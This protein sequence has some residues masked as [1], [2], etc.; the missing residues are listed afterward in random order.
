MQSTHT[1]KVGWLKTRNY[2]HVKVASITS[3]QY[4]RDQLSKNGRKKT[5]ALEDIIRQYENQTQ[6][7]K[8]WTYTKAWH[9]APRDD[10]KAST[11]YNEPEI[12]SN[13]TVNL[14]T[15]NTMQNNIAMANRARPVQTLNHAKM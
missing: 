6:Q 4:L 14:H 5:D 10:M 11:Q 13:C 3:E 7:D 1:T 8:N 15:I 9:D 12:P 2:K